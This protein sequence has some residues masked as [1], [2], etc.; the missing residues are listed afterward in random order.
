MS[1]QTSARSGTADVTR[2]KPGHDRIVIDV[3]SVLADRPDGIE[4]IAIAGL[5][6][7]VEQ[8]D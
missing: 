8:V 3:W 6:I 5:G 4:D 7:V 2:H 1:R